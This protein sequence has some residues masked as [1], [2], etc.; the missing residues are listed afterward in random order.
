MASRSLSAGKKRGTH[1]VDR[2]MSTGT[3]TASAKPS[4]SSSPLNDTSRN[5][6]KKNSMIADTSM[7]SGRRRCLRA[8]CAAM[9]ASA[10]A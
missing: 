2:R 9:R 7:R 8:D 4:H 10:R 6:V 1:I 3:I 5:A